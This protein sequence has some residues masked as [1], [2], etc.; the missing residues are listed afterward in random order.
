MVK[1]HPRQAKPG[2]KPHF[3]P[4]PLHSQRSI[5]YSKPHLTYKSRQV[6]PKIYTSNLQAWRTIGAKEGVRGI[7][8]GWAPTFVGYS[9]QG[10]GKYGF[11]EIFKYV[12]GDKWAP[13]MNKTVSL[14]V[15]MRG[16]LAV[17]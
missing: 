16:F 1:G 11:Y 8:F 6:D 13:N 10:A 7:F 4:T 12:Y 17:D 9:F 15:F 14:H 2:F 5:C 3:T